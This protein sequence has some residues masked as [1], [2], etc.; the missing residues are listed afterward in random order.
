MRK[1]LLTLLLVLAPFQAHA[2]FIAPTGGD[3]LFGDVTVGDSATLTASFEVTCETGDVICTLFAATFVWQGGYTF[4]PVT[5]DDVAEGSTGIWTVDVTFNPLDIGT[6]TGAVLLTVG[7]TF[8]TDT[9]T[10]SVAF[11]GN[12]VAA[13]VPEPSSITLA[14]LGLAVLAFARRR[15]KMA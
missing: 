15:R 11:S 8:S 2:L 1:G 12:G 3:L 6:F 10:A 7:S 9:D 4:G 13:S 14:A 5:A